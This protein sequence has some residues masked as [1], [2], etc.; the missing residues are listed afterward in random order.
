MI[1]FLSSP[2]RDIA[3]LYPVKNLK[4]ETQK[5]YYDQVM[6]LVHEVGFNVVAICVDNAPANRKIYKDFLCK[7]SIQEYIP[8]NTL[9][10][11]LFLHLI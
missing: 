3:G 5:T 6:A 4:P 9:D 2:Y 11:K 10:E 1:K 7:G 8:M